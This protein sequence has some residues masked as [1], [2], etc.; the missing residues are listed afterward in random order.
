MGRKGEKT[1][2]RK[3]EE[4]AGVG[5]LPQPSPTTGEGIWSWPT[6]LQGRLLV[7]VGAAEGHSH[8]GPARKP[9][10]S[11]AMS[12]RISPRP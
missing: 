1:L 7:V 6:S 8:T 11:Q 4:G 2:W 3:M 10:W 9:G 12:P 5:G